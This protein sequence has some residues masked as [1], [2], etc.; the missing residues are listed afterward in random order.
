MRLLLQWLERRNSQNLTKREKD[1]LALLVQGMNNRE[2]AECL[3]ISRSTAGF[4]VGNILSTL[5][6]TNRAKAVASAYRY[7][8][9]S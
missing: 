5:G 4:H 1:V 3:V 6:A 9:I 2:I 8:L 7:K